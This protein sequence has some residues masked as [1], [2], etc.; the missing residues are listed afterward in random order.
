LKKSRLYLGLELQI[1]GV[2]FGIIAAIVLTHPVSAQFLMSGGRCA[3][4]F[5]PPANSGTANA[6]TDQVALPGT[7]STFSTSSVFR[8]ACPQ[9]LAVV[10]LCATIGLSHRLPDFPRLAIRQQPF[11]ISSLFFE[12]PQEI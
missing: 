1:R 11:R 2:V 8:Q 6:W 7:N 3:Q 5:D 10:L 4:N 9:P 12:R